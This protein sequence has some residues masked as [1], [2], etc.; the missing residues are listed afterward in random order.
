[1][2]FSVT[3][4]KQERFSILLLELWFRLAALIYLNINYVNMLIRTHQTP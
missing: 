2:D 4:R 3:S 1:M